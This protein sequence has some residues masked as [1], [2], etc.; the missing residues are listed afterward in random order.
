M[1][2][3][4]I[5]KVLYLAFG[6]RAVASF[7]KA[8]WE[9]IEPHTWRQTDTLG[10][11]YR[12]FL[13]FTHEPFSFKLFLPAVLQSGDGNGILPMEFPLLNLVFAPLWAFGPYWGKV[14][15]Y[16]LFAA[17]TFG[18]S[19]WLSRTKTWLAPC[20][21]LLPFLSFS[22]DYIEKF[23]PDTAATLLVLLGLFELL[24]VR[25]FRGQVLITL[26]LLVKPTAIIALATLFLFSKFRKKYVRYCLLLV[27]PVLVCG[28]YYTVGMKLIDHYRTGDLLIFAV[29][30]RN[31]VDALTQI[32]SNPAFIYNQFQNRLFM[33]YGGLIFVAGLLISRNLKIIKLGSLALLL[34]FLQFTAIAALDGAHSA[35]HDYYYMGISPIAAA[36]FYYLMRKGQA[37]YSS[38]LLIL[39][40]GHACEL[41]AQNLKREK[42]YGFYESR[43]QCAELKVNHPEFPW[44]QDYTFRSRDEPYPSLGLCFGERQ[45][46][47]LAQYGLFY[48]ADPVP[49]HCEAVAH[50]SIYQLVKCAP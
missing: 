31:P 41:A 9:L 49:E 50:S 33:A 48:L 40:F 30:P 47:K 22:A 4:K 29:S 8:F 10:V 15:I 27:P 44:D 11:S 19:F 14:A 43:R 25:K 38:F 1:S 46:S 7:V 28:L 34:M 5:L 6:L 12:Y 42:I 37:L 3:S 20:F 18:V 35:Q 32:F 24:K 13:R 45:G 39:L 36:S 21:L 17:F 16:I 23:I 2:R 26:G